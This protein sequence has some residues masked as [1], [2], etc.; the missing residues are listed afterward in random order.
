[1]DHHC[2][3]TGNCIGLYNHKFFILFLFYA[4]VGLAIISFNILIDWIAGRKVMGDVTEDWKNYAVK[5]VGIAS[6]VLM[7]SI[8]FLLFT[9]VLSTIINLTTLESFTNGIENHVFCVYMFRIHLIKETYHKISSK[10]VGSRDAI[11]C[12]LLLNSD[13][14]AIIS[15]IFSI[16]FDIFIY[17][18]KIQPKNLQNQFFNDHNHAITKNNTQTMTLLQQ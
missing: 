15:M 11:C 2:P 9:Q 13:L 17:S 10:Y 5:I 4:T 18:I 14:K 3:W 12:P 7:I 1:M 8:G 16:I 6:F